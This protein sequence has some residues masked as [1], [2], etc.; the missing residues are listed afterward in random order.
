MYLAAHRGFTSRGGEMRCAYRPLGQRGTKVFVW[1]VCGE[2]V[3]VGD[4]LVDGSAMN[5]PAAFEIRVD[6]GRPRIVGVEVPEDGEGYGRSIRRIFPADIFANVGADPP[7]AG[8]GN[9][10]RR[11]AAARFGLPP[12]AAS[13]PR[14]HEPPPS[15]GQGGEA[16]SSPAAVD[17]AARHVVE[18]LQGKLPFERIALGDTVTIYVSPEGGA[19]RATFRRDQLRR[20]SAWVVRSA[21]RDVSLV[22]SAHMTELST[23]VGRHFNCHEEPIGAKYPRLSR[24]PHVGTMLRPRNS[25]SCL[26]T[27][28]VTFVFD[29]SATPRVVAALYDQW[30]W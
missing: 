8:L 18:F 15:M 29:R 21:G 16:T 12:A 28:N 1:A 9:H 24:F 20:P 11:E 14:V 7:A 30:E 4:H 27:W 2:L 6:S 19:G 23:K 5:I 25:D 3:A 22:P 17:S 13:A 10:L 26:Q